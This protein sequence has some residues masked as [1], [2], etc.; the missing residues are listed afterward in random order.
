MRP[1]VLATPPV[2]LARSVHV[3]RSVLPRAPPADRFARFAGGL[4][5][6]VVRPDGV[7]DFGDL[8]GFAADADFAF[9]ERCAPRP[10][11]VRP[12]PRPRVVEP[13]AMPLR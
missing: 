3:P 7:A 5:A 6:A 2:P 10:A 11:P 12:V 13:L 4:R 1:T 8:A 9:A